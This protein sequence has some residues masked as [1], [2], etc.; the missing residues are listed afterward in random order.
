[1]APTRTGERT[2]SASKISAFHRVRQ[3]FDRPRVDD[4]SRGV[5]GELALL[6]SEAC[7]PLLEGR[8]GIQVAADPAPLAFDGRGRLRSP[9]VES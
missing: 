2:L 7:R 3:S 5:R 1:M 9:F 8:S 6:V 4:F